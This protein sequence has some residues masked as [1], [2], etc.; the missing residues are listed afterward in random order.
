MSTPERADIVVVG[1]GIAGAALA[2]S[3]AREDLDVLVLERDRH[4]RDVNKGECI[5]PWGWAEVDRLSL[6]GVLG[7]HA[8]LVNPAWTSI[9]PD[10]SATAVPVGA[11][12]S[13]APGSYSIGH[14][15][16]RRALAD[17]ARDAGATLR[18][19]TANVRLEQGRIPQV[20]WEEDG[21]QH[22]TRTRM[23]V[24]ADG[25]GSRVRRQ[26]GLSLERGER[27]HVI[28]SLLVENTRDLGDRVVVAAA[29]RL[30]LLAVPLPD[31]RARLYLVSRDQRF[32]GTADNQRML[33]ACQLPCLDDVDRFADATPIGPCATYGGEDAWVATPA[34][35]AAVLVGDAAGYNSPIIGQGLSLALRD[36]RLV[37]EL[38]LGTSHWSGS[39]FAPYV[40]ERAERLR[41]VRFVAQ[42]W[43]QLWLRPE[44]EVLRAFEHP[45]FQEL[46]VGLFAGYDDAPEEWFTRDTRQSLV[47]A[48]E[49]PEFV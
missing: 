35:D 42:L 26:L 7:G 14:V 22:R 40:R 18:F 9:R 16:A 49:H 45:R 43:A 30:M 21:R 32:R 41:R 13:D 1:G 34:T 5:L 27:T 17:A 33:Q 8:G 4:Y 11:L 44:N 38:L 20:T 46:L 37:A 24:G 39:L 10:G 19:G 15:T 25:R 29:N 12:R 47:T 23:V 36:V 48:V 31:R 28:A 3:L 2:T 6:G